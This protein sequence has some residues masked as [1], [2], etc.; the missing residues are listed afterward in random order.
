MSPLELCAACA[1]ALV[2]PIVL[3]LVIRRC[4]CPDGVRPPRVF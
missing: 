1:G 2:M 3:S 4:R